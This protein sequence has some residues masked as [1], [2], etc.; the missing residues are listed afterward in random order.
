MSLVDG[1]AYNERL[2]PLFRGT[3]QPDRNEPVEYISYDLWEAMRAHDR[4]MADEVL[5]PTFTFM[6]AQ[7]DPRRLTTMKLGQYLEYR[8]ADVGKA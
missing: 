7:T 8:E 3:A 6:R 4:D 2:M 5:E 1:R